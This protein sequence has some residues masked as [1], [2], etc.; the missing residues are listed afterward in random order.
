MLEYK[1]K[2]WS[3]SYKLVSDG[4]MALS[5]GNGDQELSSSRLF[6]SEYW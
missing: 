4:L 6:W 2:R 3:G 1:M 5:L